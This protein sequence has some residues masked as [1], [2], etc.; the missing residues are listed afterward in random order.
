MGL[1][2]EQHKQLSES[3]KE[4][5]YSQDR[6]QGE[7]DH[8]TAI[9]AVLRDKCGINEK[10]FKRVAKAYWADTVKKDYEDAT[11]QADLFDLARGFVAPVSQIYGDS[12]G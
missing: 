4:W 7:Q 11:L 3:I 5:G 12:E 8:Q 1:T 2:A 10:H 6:I 9:A